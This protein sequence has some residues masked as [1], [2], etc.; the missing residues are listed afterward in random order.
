MLQAT[1][2]TMHMPRRL[3]SGNKE[4]DK[5]VE[6]KNA[7]ETMQRGRQFWYETGQAIVQSTFDVQNR[8]LQYV[9]NSFTDGVETLKNHI[10]ASQHWMQTRN[11]PQDQQEAM[12][13]LMENG[14]EAYKRNIAL[15]Q[16]ITE[17]GTEAF[18]AN[19]EVAR[20][21]TQTLMKKAQDRPSLFL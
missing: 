11:K 3:L 8:S 10:E 7:S 20:D 15:F 4:R 21:L 1:G 13:S 6:E 19:A 18:R 17:H 5:I 12:P 16:R 2:L 9:Q 14:V